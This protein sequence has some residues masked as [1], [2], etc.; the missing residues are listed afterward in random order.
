MARYL[1]YTFLL[2]LLVAFAGC[3]GDDE[4]VFY[5]YLEGGSIQGW[6]VRTNGIVTTFAGTAG[7]SGSADGIGTAALFND[8]YGITTDG[9]NLYVADESNS[10][11]RK[12]VIATGVVTTLAGQAGVSGSAD[13]V[14]TAATFNDP[15]SITT[16]GKN[17]YVG[18]FLNNNIRK[19]VIATGVVTTLAGQAGTSGST[20]GIGAAA[21]FNNPSGVTT[22]GRNLYVAERG[23][24]TIRKIVISTGEVTTLAGQAGVTGSA[25]GI[26]TAATFN[27]PDELTT[28][29]RNLFVPD[30]GNNSIRKIVISSGVVTT[31]AGSGTATSVDGFGLAA[32]FNRPEGITTDGRNLF[33]T[34]ESGHVIRK[35]VIATGEVTTVAGSPGV[36]GSADGTGPAAR[37]D[38]PF[39]ITTDGY[40]LYVSD[41]AN[42]TIRR[43]Q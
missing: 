23:N 30:R 22:D 34:E 13:G 36:T 39:G 37:F 17:L 41:L 5:R 18:D 29:G 42:H 28:D 16:D 8:P 6:P 9:K 24:N 10:T 4:N 2:C 12:I 31:L 32:S 21:R 33:V 19:I 15:C 27:D 43:I 38:R 1:R 26:G 11:I 35:V 25:D 14:G 3:G 7:V 20:D 40:D